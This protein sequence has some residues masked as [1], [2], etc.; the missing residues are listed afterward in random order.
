MRRHL[1]VFG[2]LDEA[3]KVEGM[4]ECRL[5]GKRQMMAK[6]AS[7]IQSLRVPIEG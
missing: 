5:F 4:A 3:I 1:D 7:M 6:R 2:D